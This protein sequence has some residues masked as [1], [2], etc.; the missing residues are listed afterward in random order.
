MPRFGD[1]SS[2]FSFQVWIQT[3]SDNIWYT[4]GPSSGDTTDATV[5]AENSDGTIGDTYYFEG[6]GSLPWGNTDLAVSSVPGEPG[7]THV[8]T[9]GARG[10][11]VGP[12][13]NCAEMTSDI[14]EGVA[15]SC[16]S[17]EVVAP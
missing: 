15:I 3:G 8:I 11:S 4:Y 12:W 6:T 5:G 16:A 9:F 10:R 7:E 2:R 1:S 14:F 13:T 17:G